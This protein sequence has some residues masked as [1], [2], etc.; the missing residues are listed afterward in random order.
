MAISEHNNNKKQQGV[1]AAASARKP[2]RRPTAQQAPTTLPRSRRNDNSCSG[3]KQQ[4]AHAA[5]VSSSLGSAASSS[6]GGN[7]EYAWLEPRHDPIA[8]DTNLAEIDFEDF[9]NEDLAYAFSC[10][11]SSMFAYNGIK[12]G[13]MFAISIVSVL[14]QALAYGLFKR[15]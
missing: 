8:T 6:G 14:T 11:V 10:G 7:M 9:R 4:R 1:A 2:P 15:C 13:I 3:N 5:A 12:R